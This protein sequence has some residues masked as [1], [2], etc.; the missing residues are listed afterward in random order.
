MSFMGMEVGDMPEA[1]AFGNASANA[2]ACGYGGYPQPGDLRQTDNRGPADSV[3]DGVG[4]TI[5]YTGAAVESTLR[6]DPRGFIDNIAAGTGNALQA[7]TLGLYQ[8]PD[9]RSFGRAKE[10]AAPKAGAAFNADDHCM[11]GPQCLGCNHRKCA[12]KASAK[13]APPATTGSPA[14]ETKAGGRCKWR[15][16]CPGCPDCDKS[17]AAACHGN[18]KASGEHE[19]ATWSAVTECM[20]TDEALACRRTEQLKASAHDHGQAIACP[21]SSGNCRRVVAA[22]NKEDPKA[23]AYYKSSYVFCDC[24]QADA[25]C[26]CYQSAGSGYG[27]G[28]TAYAQE[29]AAAEP[30]Y[31]LVGP[32]AGGRC[33]ACD[34]YAKKSSGKCDC[35]SLKLVKA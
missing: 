9:G 4:D 32:H 30:E 29:N 7:A 22:G 23:G 34:V 6:G 24:D 33:M 35:G 13:A 28:R 18:A 2:G 12:G 20:Q 5:G 1:H 14:P 19:L 16:N 15:M 10:S 27:Y 17:Y 21:A 3:G 31:K 26:V 25:S 11:F 8:E